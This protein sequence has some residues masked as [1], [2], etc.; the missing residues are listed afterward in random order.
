MHTNAQWCLMTISLKLAVMIAGGLWLSMNTASANTA[1]VQYSLP[2]L[3]D[4]GN[5]SFPLFDVGLGTLSEV[6]ISVTNLHTEGLVTYTNPSD[7]FGVFELQFTPSFRVNLSD[8]VEVK[9]PYVLWDVDVTEY[10]EPNSSYKKF[11]ADS[12]QSF[13]MTYSASNQD[14]S[15]LLGSGTGSL[16]GSLDVYYRLEG[17]TPNLVWGPAGITSTTTYDVG[18]TYMYEPVQATPE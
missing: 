10:V 11:W 13:T 15:G 7:T 16:S 2:R 6:L 5:Q 12:A 14:L 4:V 8:V 3:R 18:V 1:Q 9:V 17:H